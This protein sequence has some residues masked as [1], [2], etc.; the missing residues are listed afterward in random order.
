MPN[1]PHFN[2]VPPTLPKRQ[3]I[4]RKD[5]NNMPMR[6]MNDAHGKGKMCADATLAFAKN[7]VT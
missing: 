6:I 4:E 5:I 2:F 3:T 1:I 7:M